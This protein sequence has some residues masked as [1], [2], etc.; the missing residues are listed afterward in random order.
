MYNRPSIKNT[1]VCDVT[2]IHTHMHFSTHLPNCTAL[3]PRRQFCS[4]SEDLQPTFEDSFPRC[5]SSGIIVT[6]DIIP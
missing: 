1:V 4:S 6:N 3:Q 2:L 5:R